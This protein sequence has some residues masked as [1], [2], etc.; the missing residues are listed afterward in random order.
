MLYIA[1]I[2]G[3]FHIV[4]DTYTQLV[5]LPQGSNRGKHPT[6]DTGSTGFGFQNDIHHMGHTHTHTSLLRPITHLITSI[7]YTVHLSTIVQPLK[8]Y[9][10]QALT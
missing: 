1:F 4:S 8:L 10:E 3:Q 2:A 7:H 6:T 5:T 9:A